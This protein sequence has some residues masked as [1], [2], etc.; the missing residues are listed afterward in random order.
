MESKCTVNIVDHPTIHVIPS[1]PLVRIRLLAPAAIKPSAFSSA[2]KRDS[3]VSI[4]E[5]AFMLEIM[6]GERY[7][8][9]H[10]V[11]CAH[12]MCLMC[13]MMQGV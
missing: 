6:D 8:R 13:H 4:V 1:L 11:V 2:R 3:I 5:S 7:I 10:D 9:S 12:M